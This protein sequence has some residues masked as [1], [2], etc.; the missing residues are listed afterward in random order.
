MSVKSSE[1]SANSNI[2]NPKSSINPS[3]RH[4]EDLLEDIEVAIRVE[5]HRI[6]NKRLIYSFL[7]I[8]LFILDIFYPFLDTIDN[9]H[10]YFINNE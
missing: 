5:S 10:F 7:D 1:S 6:I 3:T 8:F 9:L 2:N 4:P